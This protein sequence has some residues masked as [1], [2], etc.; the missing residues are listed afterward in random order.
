M[1]SDLK[2][3]NHAGHVYILTN[4]A[5]PGL[6]K[7]GHTAR[8]PDIRA[9]ELSAA[10]GVPGR[11]VVAWSHPVRDHEALESLAHGRLDRYRVNANR[12]FFSCTVAQARR[13]IEQEARA[14]LLPG[15]GFCC[16][17]WCIPCP[18]APGRRGNRAQAGGGA[19]KATCSDS[20]PW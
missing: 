9:A 1:R 11:F 12:E 17:A 2:S 16:T 5:M 18:P 14:Q 15:G 3:I 4:P 19:S 7:I 13:I 10:T 8:H 20:M 6:V